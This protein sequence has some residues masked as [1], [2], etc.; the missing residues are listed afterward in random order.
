M[1]IDWSKPIEAVTSDVV[2]TAKL[3]HTGHGP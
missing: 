1:K 3:V 2:K